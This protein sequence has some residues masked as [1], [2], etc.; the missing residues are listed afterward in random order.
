MQSR[1]CGNPFEDRTRSGVALGARQGELVAASGN[2][3]TFGRHRFTI[4]RQPLD[5]SLVP[6][7]NGLSFQ[8]T[9][10]DYNAPV[11]DER[12]EALRAFWDQALV[13]ETPALARAEYLA[14]CLWQAALRGE[15]GLDGPA[16]V[17]LVVGG[18]EGTNQE[19]LL[20]LV[21]RFAAPATRRA[22]RKG[23][24]TTMPASCSL[25]W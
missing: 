1:R 11:V 18:A 16:L 21:R 7:Q 14:G 22:I 15:E 4:Q 12:L 13:S 2:T 8:I 25:P 9:G 20:E 24:T 6:G 3:L 17:Q 5:L 19:A 10:T 23:C